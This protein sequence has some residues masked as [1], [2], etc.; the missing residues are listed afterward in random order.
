[1]D[2]Y[3]SEIKGGNLHIFNKVYEAYHHKLYAYIFHKTSSAFYAQEVVQLTFIK[4]WE[5]RQNISED[6]T[7]SVQLFKI[8]RSILIDTLRK[9]AIR[10]KHQDH[11]NKNF[12]PVIHI[13]SYKDTMEAVDYEIEKMPRVRREVFKLSRKEGFSYKEIAELLSISP[14]T[15]ENHISAAI[16]QLKSVMG[17]FIPEIALVIYI[18]F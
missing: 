16:K 14:K 1:M 9:E 15:V 3:L 10:Q 12:T 7:L 2:S 17:N 8:A 11:A 5:K 6:Y 4:L 18:I 13:E